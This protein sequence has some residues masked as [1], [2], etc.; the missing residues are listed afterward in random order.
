VLT[1]RGRYNLGPRVLPNADPADSSLRFCYFAASEN[2]IDLMLSQSTGDGRRTERRLLR[3]GLSPQFESF[4]LFQNRPSATSGG[5]IAVSSKRGGRDAIYILRATNGRVLRRFDFPRLVA[6]TNPSLLPGDTA[7]VFSAQDY[8][9]RS[10]LY[11][12]RWQ[13]RRVVLEHLTQDDWDDL[14][15]DVS[16]D[17]GW[18]VFASDRGSPTGRYALWRLSLEDGRVERMSS[19]GRGDDRQPSYSPDGRW[20]AFRSTRDGTSDLYVRPAAPSSEARRVTRLLGPASDPDWLTRGQGLVFT[21]QSGIEFQCYVAHFD[22]DTLEAESESPAPEAAAASV[23]L[24]DGEPQSYQRRLGLD[25][26]QNAV[27][28]DPVLGG[29]GVGQIALSDVLGDEQYYIFIL[30]QSLDRFGG[31]WDGLEAGVTYINQAHRL[32]YGAGVYRLVTVY[33]RDL[34]AIRLERRLGVTLLARYPFDKFNRVEGSI[35]LRRALDHLLR[36]GQ[37]LDVDLVSNFVAFIH[38]NAAWNRLGPSA[39]SRLILSAGYTRDL[40]SGASDYGTLLAEMRRYW[41]PLPRVVSATRVQ[42]QASLGRDAQRFYLGGRMTLRG[43]DY[44]TLSG[45]RTVVVQQELRFPL[46][47]GLRFAFPVPWE[48][49]PVN[50]AAFVDAGWAWGGGDVPVAGV[51]AYFL[52]A[53]DLGPGGQGKLGSVGVGFYIGGGPYPVVRWNYA[54]QTPDFRRFSRRP[55]T[56]FAIGYNF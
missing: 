36:D 46:L 10:D 34:N 48:F 2:G 4:H 8:G 20:I 22:P 5:L 9:G 12:A 28:V 42:G 49:P 17:G 47:Q 39:G 53:F 27:A 7:M 16:P 13:G 19:P 50:G 35:L 3:G 31:F 23:A 21:G 45:L 26:V 24:H 51:P 52:S 41:S 37:V 15:P 43:Y 33:D 54:W 44:H 55:R 11:R 14:E 40:G 18:V 6:I 32:N 56:Q 30:N 29:G 38:D 25:L 1:V